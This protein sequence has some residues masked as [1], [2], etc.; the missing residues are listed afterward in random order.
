VIEWKEQSVGIN[1]DDLKNKAQN[2][3]K[4]HGDKIEQGVEKAGDLAKKKF[5][6]GDQVDKVVDKVQDAIPDKPGADKPASE[7]DDK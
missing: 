4:E 2:L 7:Q 1:F 6:H 5:G 3:V